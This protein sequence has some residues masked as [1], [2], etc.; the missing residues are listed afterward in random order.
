[1]HIHAMQITIH[2]QVAMYIHFANQQAFINMCYLVAQYI[3]TFAY[4]ISI[5]TCT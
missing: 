2:D 4:K 3:A 5:T 1:M